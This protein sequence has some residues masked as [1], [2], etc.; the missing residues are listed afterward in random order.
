VTR[1]V[2]T[3][4]AGFVGGALVRRLVADGVNVVAT[5]VR[6]A[7]LPVETRR[8]DITDADAVAQLLGGADVVYHAASMVQTS[9]THL[10]RLRAVNVGGTENLLRAA[11]AADVAR[12]V[13]VSSASV[14]YEGRDIHAGDESLPYASTT[15][16]PYSDTKIEAE[17]LVHAA[18]D[19][20]GLRTI[21]I[22]PHVVYGPGDGR[23]MP[24]IYDRAL[25]GKLTLGVGRD[26]R[27]SDF[28]YIDNLVDALV[29]ADAAL[30]RDASLGGRPYFVNDGQ[31]RAFWDFVDAVLVE[32]GLPKTRGRVPFAVAYTV[33][34]VAEGY[35]AMRGVKPGHED[36]LTRYAVRYMCTHHYF[37]ISAARTAL[38]YAPAVDTDTGI[39]RTIAAFRAS[40]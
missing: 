8:V 33:A 6:D 4:A 10:D 7:A 17:R 15:Q 14:V 28:T 16:S 39:R 20:A 38:G 32:L 12:F 24:A 30:V 2:V 5:D 11:A 3:G 26:Q 36:G 9:W 25:A 21:S 1:A 22:R 18:H 34:A 27:L 23:F 31:P 19:A 37:D 13:Y 40:R 29:L 35:R